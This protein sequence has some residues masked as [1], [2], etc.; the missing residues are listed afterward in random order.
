MIKKAPVNTVK[1]RNILAQIE[2]G[3]KELDT[4]S[5]LTLNDFLSD[6]RNYIVAEHYLRRCLERILTIGSHFLSRINAKTKDYQ[7]IILSL[8][9]HGLIPKDFA[10]RNKNL[11][12]YRNRLVHIYWEIT[13]EELYNVINQHLNDLIEFCKYYQDILS[14]LK[15]YGL[16]S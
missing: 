14:N 2:E 8:G 12:G 5:R 7:Q 15:K 11:A 1:V 9:D 10:E 13:P 6:K 4:L 3:I 16:K